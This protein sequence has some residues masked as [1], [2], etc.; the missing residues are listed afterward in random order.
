MNIMGI[1]EEERAGEGGWTGC[2]E[3]VAG[4]V[5]GEARIVG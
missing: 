1:S 3:G 5:S 4:C 2:E